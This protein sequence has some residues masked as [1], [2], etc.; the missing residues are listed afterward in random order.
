MLRAVAREPGTKAK[1]TRTTLPLIPA[2]E[3]HRLHMATLDELTFTLPADSGQ[4]G[5]IWERLCQ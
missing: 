4:K 5:K 1:Q 3:Y 2:S